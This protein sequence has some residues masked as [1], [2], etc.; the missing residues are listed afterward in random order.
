[1][2]AI[3]VLVIDT[4]ESTA[5]L[6][7]TDLLQVGI[8]AVTER[9]DSRAGIEEG[10]QWFEPDLVLAEFGLPEI[11]GMETLELVR[12]LRPAIPFIFISQARAEQQ[13][14]EALRQGALDYVPK[15]DR[16]RLLSAVR[17]A[18]NEAFERR[19]R[20]DA[21]RAPGRARRTRRGSG[22]RARGAAARRPPTS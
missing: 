3:R 22:R 19:V 12:R 9:T 16:V 6:L 17:H 4:S 14:L 21:E 7:A 15:S 11:G 8:K 13:E 18:L 20:R 10:L 2:N 5:D 1:M